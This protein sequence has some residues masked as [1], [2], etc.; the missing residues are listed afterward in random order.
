[1]IRP[2]KANENQSRKLEAW[3]V[4]KYLG[5]GIYS[6]WTAYNMADK[7]L[8]SS[9]INFFTLSFLFFYSFIFF[10]HSYGCLHLIGTLFYFPYYLIPHYSFPSYYA[11]IFVHNL[12]SFL[13]AFPPWVTQWVY[14]SLAPRYCIPLLCTRKRK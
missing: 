4:C 6:W 8:T 2:N 1:M 10:F 13:F 14:W 9:I 7:H 12:Y 5:W 3:Y 11:Y